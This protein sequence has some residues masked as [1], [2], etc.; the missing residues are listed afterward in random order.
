MILQLLLKPL[1][2]R[3]ISYIIIIIIQVLL[4][5]VLIYK[6]RKTKIK[7][8]WILALLSIAQAI[9]YINIL[10]GG[11]RIANQILASTEQLSWLVIG[12]IFYVIYYYFVIS[13]S[14]F[15]I[16]VFINKTFYKKRNTGFLLVLI[17]SI[18]AAII[19]TS[20]Q[21]IDPYYSKY[22][23][24]SPHIFVWSHFVL[25]AVPNIWCSQTILKEYM[26]YR[27][28]DIEPWIRWR[29]FIAGTA[30]LVYATL[31][32][33]Q[34]IWILFGDLQTGTWWLLFTTYVFTI[35]SFFAWAMPKF[36]KDFFNRNYKETTEPPLSEEDFRNLIKKKDNNS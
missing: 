17:I 8:L 11:R 4:A 31:G 7:N 19:L 28:L 33:A 6:V 1:T 26:N 36:L 2:T 22:P 9:V 12:S 21:I 15:L 3:E 20:I 35:L 34:I 24:I 32:F 10:S 30:H 29:Y 14:Y 25:V 16:V 5:I 27:K 13:L 18:F 23:D